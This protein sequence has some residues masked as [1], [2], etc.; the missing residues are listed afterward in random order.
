MIILNL[1][2]T[3]TENY[4][5][6]ECPE[7]D[8]I[9]LAVVNECTAE[10]KGNPTSYDHFAHFTYILCYLFAKHHFCNILILDSGILTY[11]VVEFLHCIKCLFYKCPHFVDL[12]HWT[13]AFAL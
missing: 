11:T 3:I 9:A 7:Y 4:S 2:V 10:W 13:W 12:L 1:E 8:M 5:T 6:Q